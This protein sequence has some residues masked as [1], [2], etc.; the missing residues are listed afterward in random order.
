MLGQIREFFPYL[1]NSLIWKILTKLPPKIPKTRTEIGFLDHIRQ[2]LIFFGSFGRKIPL[3]VFPY[4]DSPLYIKL[5][6]LLES[7]R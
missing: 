2:I 6:I 5:L 1:Y 3:F 7:N 4:L